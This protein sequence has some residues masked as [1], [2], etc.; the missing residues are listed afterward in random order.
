MTL[1]ACSVTGGTI[2]FNC[3][4]LG[5]IAKLMAILYHFVLG[6]PVHHLRGTMFRMT[7]LPIDRFLDTPGAAAQSA[8]GN[9]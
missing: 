5:H 9:A 7:D 3:G 6:T 8:Q 1:A 4:M 2:M